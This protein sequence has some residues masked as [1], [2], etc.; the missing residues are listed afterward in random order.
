MSGPIIGD[1]GIVFG[2]GSEYAQFSNVTTPIVGNKVILIEIAGGT[3]IAVPIMAFDIGQYSWAIPSFRFAG[4]DWKIDWDLYLLS[5]N[6]WPNNYK[7]HDF[8]I[9]FEAGGTYYGDDPME[10]SGGCLKI[11]DTPQQ[12]EIEYAFTDGIFE[13]YPKPDDCSVCLAAAPGGLEY[14]IMAAPNPD[15]GSSDHASVYFFGDL[16]WSGSLQNN[17][18]GHIFAHGI[19]TP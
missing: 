12:G 3:Q 9:A 4:F 10:E 14:W 11:T 18:P 17:T 7:D 2:A 6:R 1:K 19:W 15:Y 16:V 8:M 5:F 13:E